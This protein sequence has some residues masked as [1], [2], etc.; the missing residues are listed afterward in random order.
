MKTYTKHKIIR[1]KSL[2]RQI[3]DQPSA[4]PE[5]DRP[6]EIDQPSANPEIDRPSEIDQPSANTGLYELLFQT[7]T[8]NFSPGSQ[9]KIHNSEHWFYVASEPRAP[10]SRLIIDNR[11]VPMESWG[12]SIKIDQVHCI[13][14][15]LIEDKNPAFYC[16]G[17]AVAIPL[18]Y[19]STFPDRK[20][21]IVYLGPAISLEFLTSR[22]D[23]V[24][25]REQIDIGRKYYCKDGVIRNGIELR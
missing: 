7:E 8:L 11:D 13:Y 5:I 16:S 4:N 22:T 17:T 12:E 18:S 3:F 14:P 2:D 23:L 24:R 6:S 10:W 9:V 21:T 19:I 15:E 25:S 20:P 1:V